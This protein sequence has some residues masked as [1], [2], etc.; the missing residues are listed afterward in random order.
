MSDGETPEEAIINGKDAL[1]CWVQACK[2][3]GRNKK[4]SLVPMLLRGNLE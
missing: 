2:D 1:Q 4:S 3:A